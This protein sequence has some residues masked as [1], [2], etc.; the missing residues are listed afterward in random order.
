MYSC[1]RLTAQSV[2][3]RESFGDLT[4]ITLIST[5]VYVC[6]YIH[7]YTHVYVYICHISAYLSL[8]I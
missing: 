6:V 1:E 2:E 3:L 5:C 7:I 4:T 8:Y